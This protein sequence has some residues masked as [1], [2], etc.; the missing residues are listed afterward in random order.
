MKLPPKWRPLARRRA[1][2]ETQRRE[3]IRRGLAFQEFLWSQRD[4]GPIPL[5]VITQDGYQGGM[6]PALA[7]FLRRL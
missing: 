3:E 1:I 6:D 7:E 5:G 2:A 4:R